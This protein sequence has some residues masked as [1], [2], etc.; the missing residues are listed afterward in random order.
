MKDN[1]EP[2]CPLVIHW[3]GKILPEIFGEGSV[4]RLPVLVSGDGMD[5]LL[6]VPKMS[7]GTSENEA[8]AVQKF[9]VE[10]QLV[11][12]VQAMCL[13]TTSVNTSRING[14]CVGLEDRLGI[15]LHRLACCHH[16]IEII[17]SKV[18]TI[19]CAPSNSPDIPLFK[20]PKDCWSVI[21]RQNFSE[22]QV[23]PVASTVYQ[24]QP[25]SPDQRAP[26]GTSQ[27]GLHGGY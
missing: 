26:K 17:L 10:C 5:K 15:E 7:S 20:R 22:F 8:N 4:D 24:M 9:L 3:N 14:V 2:T 27:R 23:K 16:V 19:C 25:C 18:F 13:D 1:F 21:T 11:E 6:D 12:K